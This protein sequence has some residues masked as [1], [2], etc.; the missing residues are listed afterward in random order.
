MASH[1][2]DPVVAGGLAFSV[3]DADTGEVLAARDADVARTPASTIKLLTAAA[4]LRLYTGD[5]VLT[6]R[7]T[8][9]DGLVT[10][11]EAVT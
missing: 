10:L 5:E 7:A 1:A 6:T 9:E 3:V 2:E 8:V 11:Q 4:V